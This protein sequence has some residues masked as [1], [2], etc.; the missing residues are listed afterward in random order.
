VATTRA[1]SPSYGE[2]ISFAFSVRSKRSQ[3]SSDWWI[4]DPEL[5]RGSEDI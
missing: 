5:P 2:P 1:R 4:H 3:A